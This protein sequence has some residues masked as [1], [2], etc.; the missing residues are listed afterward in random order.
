MD[1]QRLIPNLGEYFDVEKAAAD[2]GK[3]LDAIG[4]YDNDTLTLSNHGGQGLIYRLVSNRYSFPLLIKIPIY[5]HHRDDT[6][7]RHDILKEAQIN[8]AMTKSGTWIAPRL[9][10]YDDAGAYLIREYIAGEELGKRLAASDISERDTFLLREYAWVSE[11]FHLFHDRIEEPYVIRDLKAKNITCTDSGHLSLIDCGSCRP[12][13]QMIS[14]T[15]AGARKKLGNGKFLHWPL[16][17]FIED[18]VVCDRRIDYFAWGVLAYY[19]MFLRYPYANNVADLKAAKEA[20]DLRYLQ[21]CQEI[22]VATAMN[23]ISREMASHIKGCLNP[24]PAERRFLR[25]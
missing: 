12:E 13:R 19:T 18:P 14:R 17:Q 24:N 5:G 11:A 2:L 21:I 3:A 25:I 16:E 9:V 6:I 20:Y 7:A 23:R 10:A 1:L 22:E 8:E 4:T 15:P